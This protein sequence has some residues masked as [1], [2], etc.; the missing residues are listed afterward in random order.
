MAFE[1]GKFPGLGK[2]TLDYFMKEDV[3]VNNKDSKVRIG[4]RKSLTRFLKI[5]SQ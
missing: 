3:S 5:K 2:P 4:C 1:L